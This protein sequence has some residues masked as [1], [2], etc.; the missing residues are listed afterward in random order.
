MV[1][2][3]WN[4]VK[5]A[6]WCV[7]RLQCCRAG[8]FQQTEWGCWRRI[9]SSGGRGGGQHSP[10]SLPPSLATILGC[11]GPRPRTSCIFMRLAAARP[12]PGRRPP[13][14]HQREVWKFCG[15]VQGPG[16]CWRWPGPPPAPH[17]Q[18]SFLMQSLEL[19]LP[20]CSCCCLP[21]CPQP[22]SSYFCRPYNLPSAY[23]EP[24]QTFRWI[25][26]NFVSSY[27]ITL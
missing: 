23:T 25:N 10:A 24:G 20:A 12:S 6:R 11:F 1:T 5:F 17:P 18:P 16:S 9:R 2:W 27:D 26:M 8:L 13:P 14:R 22:S 3:L 19:L 7:W 4:F 21:I 15:R